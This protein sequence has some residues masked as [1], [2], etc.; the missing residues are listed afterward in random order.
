[1]LFIPD[2]TLVLTRDLEE[3]DKLPLTRSFRCAVV[4]VVLL[5]VGVQPEDEAGVRGEDFGDCT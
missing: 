3:T 4:V 5:V 1:M 2:C